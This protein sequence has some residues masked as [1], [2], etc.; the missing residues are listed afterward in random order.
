MSAIVIAGGGTGGHL[1]PALALA[2]QLRAQ[3]PGLAVR[4]VGAMRGLEARLLPAHGEDV[5]L[6]PARPVRGKGVATR[7]AALIWDLPRAVAMLVRRWRK[8]PPRLVVGVGGYASAAGVLAAGIVGARIA[9]MEQNAVPG[10]V[11]RLLAR[12][13]DLVLLGFAEAKQH[14]RAKRILVS[15]NPVREEILQLRWQ[16]HEP[17]VLLV[18][19]GSQGAAWLNET[20][21]RACAVLVRKGF[22][23]RVRHI[24][25]AGRAEAVRRAYEEAQVDAEVLEFC[26]RM[27]AW[28]ASGDLLVARAGAMTVTE[29]A[30]IGMP[31]VLVPLP[32][33]AGDHQRANAEALARLGAAHVCVQKDTTPEALAEI[34][35]ALLLDRARLARMSAAAR[36]APIVDRE[37]R[38]TQALLALIKEAA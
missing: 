31:C 26:E 8:D 3:R 15:G 11:N 19:G 10:A 7:L 25:G 24:A 6:L 29:A 16:A 1:M 13:A 2:K 28:Y 21:P 17:P 30:A 14:L 20:L 27:D 23:F 38:A 32:W 9:L 35:A 37:G 34:L 4:F 22:S 5:L 18:M 33:A 36:T 12:R